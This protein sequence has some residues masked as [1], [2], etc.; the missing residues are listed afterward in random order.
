MYVTARQIML[1]I[2]GGRKS[3]GSTHWIIIKGYTG[4]ATTIF[5]SGN[6]LINDPNS[7]VRVTLAQFLST[8]P[9]V[10]RLIY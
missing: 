2:I 4:T 1:V 10:L 5:S 6:F 7:S 8:Y 9:T 3:N